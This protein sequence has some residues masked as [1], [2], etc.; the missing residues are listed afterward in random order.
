MSSRNAS[1][2]SRGHDVSALELT[3]LR[4][5]FGETE[6]IRGVDLAV[7]AGERHA[8]IGPNGAGKSTL[9]A[10]ISGLYAP[11]QGCIALRGSRV[12]GLAPH[13]LSRKGLARSFQITN[14]FPRMTVF[15]NFQ[16]AAMAGLGLR[17]PLLRLGS[18][19]RQVNTNATE[20]MELVRL[21]QFRDRM[22]GDLAYSA[23]RA[24]EIGMALGPG[25]DVMLLDEPMA[26]MSRDETG[27]M[28]ELVRRVTEGK[29]LLVIEHDMDVVF[30]LCDRISVL[31][32]G[33]ILVTGTPDEIRHDTRVQQAYLGELKA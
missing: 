29:T 28:I 13:V 23:Q 18:R 19:A 11:T 15:Q 8:I 33:Q 2:A 32:Y 3:G 9:F 10:L 25:G 16:V 21:E 20:L 22:A 27:Y 26:G 4:K 14:I 1:N 12:E 6:I 24:L 31:V 17:Y 5:H 7:E 30:S